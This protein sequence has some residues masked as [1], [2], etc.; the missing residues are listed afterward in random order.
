MMQYFTNDSFSGNQFCTFLNIPIPGNNSPGYFE[1]FKSFGMT[2]KTFSEKANSLFDEYNI[3]VP[4]NY[5]VFNP[6][7]F[8]VCVSC[9]IVMKEKYDIDVQKIIKNELIDGHKSNDLYHA[10]SL[11]SIA[12]YY[13]DKGV[14]FR[15]KLTKRF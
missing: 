15:A 10:S 9:C 5:T 6:D 2:S 12:L 11:A 1:V 13:L 4:K 7:E 8:A 3:K 14:D